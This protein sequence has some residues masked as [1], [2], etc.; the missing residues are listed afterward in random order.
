MSD[1]KSRN[2]LFS[3]VIYVCALGIVVWSFG[4]VLYLA[5]EDRQ[6]VMLYQ[7]IK[8]GTVP[9]VGKT[10]VQIQIVGE[11][12]LPCK[13]VMFGEVGYAIIDGWKKEAGFRWVRD[14]SPDSSFDTGKIEPGLAELSH[15]EIGRASYIGWS[16]KH[17]CHGIVKT[18]DTVWINLKNSALDYA[19]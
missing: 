9:E 16:V 19:L 1:G 13:R 11:K 15:P 6:E 3:D 14:M 18:S 5:W 12:D 4:L 10:T 17:K 8:P 7:A 2:R